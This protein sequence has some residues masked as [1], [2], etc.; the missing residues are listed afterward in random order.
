MRFR[1]LNI[2]LA[3]CIGMLLLG[4][5]AKAAQII[6]ATG[7]YT[8]LAEM[9]EPFANAEERARE[10]ARRS[11]I[12]QVA[13]YVESSSTVQ[14]G[15]LTNDEIRAIAAGLLRIQEEECSRELIGT[16]KDI[17]FTVKIKATADASDETLNLLL[18]N[19]MAMADVVQQYRSLSSLY[20][21]EK[22]QNEEISKLFSANKEKDKKT[23]QELRRLRKESDTNMQI[24]RY[25]REAFD[26]HN[27]GRFKEAIEPLKK[28][29]SIDSKNGAAYFGLGD[30][31][32]HI[33][34]DDESLK[35]YLSALEYYSGTE[36]KDVLYNN[37]GVGYG[38][39]GDRKN[40]LLYAQKAVELAPH[41]GG[42]HFNLGT[43][44]V[45]I[46]DYEK[47]IKEFLI[48]LECDVYHNELKNRIYQNLG[49]ACSRL[50]A[51][52]VNQKDYESGIKEYTLAIE[53]DP[54]NFTAL[55]NRG[56]AYYMRGDYENA[57]NDYETYMNENPNIDVNAYIIIGGC[58]FDQNLFE[59]ALSAYDNAANLIRKDT[60][61]V[62]L[63]HIYEGRG[64][65]L[66]RLGHY[67]DALDSINHWISVEPQN[68]RAIQ[69]QKMLLEYNQ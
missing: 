66:F 2:I 63:A 30:N 53:Y 45:E 48:A 21:T 34:N 12:E 43:T 3:Y 33:G 57:F 4:N 9:E 8:M 42:W 15:K 32:H 55:F 47:G 41:N 46:G 68:P 67:K 40:A 51:A 25:F 23:E 18:R 10:E 27:T 17:R 14:E 59:E 61:S 65:A 37:I 5:V 7:T 56:S 26:L 49:V 36:Q 16:K 6:E 54:L 22:K 11:A 50:A 35:S 58:Y 60:P 1:L 13:V 52:Y 44:Y 24:Y 20:E 19:H 29:I 62:V 31:Y 69:A 64:A 28:I 38:R 39:K